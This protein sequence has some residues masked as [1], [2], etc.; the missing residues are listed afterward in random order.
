M[1]HRHGLMN[2]PV[3]GERVKRP[4]GGNCAAEAAWMEAGLCMQ[5]VASLR[6][7]IHVADHVGSFSCRVEALMWQIECSTA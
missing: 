5:A 2:V 7:Q 3:W 4:S 1:A 6:T